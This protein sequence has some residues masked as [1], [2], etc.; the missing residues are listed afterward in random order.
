MDAARKIL[1]KQQAAM[2]RV[3]AN[4]TR[5]L[6]LWTLAEE[7]KTVSEIAIAVGASLQNTS[8]HLRL[9]KEKGILKSRREAHAI[10]YHV[11]QNECPERC[12]LLLHMHQNANEKIAVR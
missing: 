7:E 6:I 10:Y 9:M 11:C 8:Q 12:Q 1:A 5:I 3:F 4:P 2:C